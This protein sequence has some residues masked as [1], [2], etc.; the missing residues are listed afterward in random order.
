MQGALKGKKAVVT[1]AGRGIGKVYDSLQDIP[2][3]KFIAPMVAY[4]ASEYGSSVNGC[5]LG[6]TGGKVSLHSLVEEFR[7]V[8]KDCKKEGPWTMEELKRIIPQTIE[9]ACP[10]L[11]S[12]PPV[13]G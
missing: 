12:P 13:G 11:R 8:F 5:V 3:P 10:P 2:S 4:L 6:C 9:A 1:G 7:A